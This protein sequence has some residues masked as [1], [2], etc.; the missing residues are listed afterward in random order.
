MTPDFTMFPWM[1]VKLQWLLA[2]TY[3][4]YSEEIA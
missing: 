1:S 2:T 4:S 3:T